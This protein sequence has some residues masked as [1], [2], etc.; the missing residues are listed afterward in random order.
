MIDSPVPKKG[1]FPPALSLRD[2]GGEKFRNQSEILG[3]EAAA[4]LRTQA[5]IG[6]LAKDAQSGQPPN[7]WSAPDRVER[8][9]GSFP[10]V[11]GIFVVKAG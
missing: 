11:V 4:S 10:A 2:E 7:I 6:S 8:G 5:G 9:S 1:I 3:R